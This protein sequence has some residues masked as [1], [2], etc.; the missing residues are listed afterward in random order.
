[1]DDVRDCSAMIELQH[2]CVNWQTGVKHTGRE[3]VTLTLR[4]CSIGSLTLL[5]GIGAFIVVV[6]IVAVAVLLENLLGLLLQEDTF[7]LVRSS[8]TSL[9][10][11]KTSIPHSIVELQPRLSILKQHSYQTTLL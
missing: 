8:Q 3:G 4:R 10:H 9:P 5:L 11:Q 6:N 7:H 2:R 1:M